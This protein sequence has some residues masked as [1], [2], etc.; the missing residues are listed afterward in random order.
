[1]HKHMTW[2]WTTSLLSLT[3]CSTA[4]AQTFDLSAAERAVRTRDYS[5]ALVLYEQAALGGDAEAQYQLANLLMLGKGVAVNE[6]L[7]LDWLEKAVQQEHPAAQYT[8]ATHNIGFDPASSI[9]LMNLAAAQNYAPARRYLDNLNQDATSE[10]LEGQALVDNWFGA[11]RRNRVDEMQL[12]LNK[13][14]DLEMTDTAQRT[15]LF[16]AIE[17][18]SPEVLSWLLD[19]NADPNHLDKFAV[20]PIFYAINKGDPSLVKTLLQAGANAGATSQNGDNLLH[21]CFGLG[22]YDLIPI[23]VE[24]G[25]PLNALDANGFSALD[26]AVLSGTDVLIQ[27]L[28][29]KGAKHSANWELSRVTNNLDGRQAEIAS[30]TDVSGMQLSDAVKIV[31]SGNSLLLR[32]LLRASPQMIQQQ[33]DDG[34]TLLT[35]S[36]QANQPDIVDVLIAE[37]AGLNFSGSSGRNALLA[38]IRLEST[39]ILKQLLDANADPTELDDD[40]FD[41]ID[42][43]IQYRNLGASQLALGFVIS[44]ETQDSA[45]TDFNRYVRLATEHEMYPLYD[46]LQAHTGRESLDDHSR[47]ALWFAA[48]NSAATEIDQLIRMGVSPQSTDQDGK[49]PLMIAV[50]KNCLVCA[51][52][53]LV[54]SDINQGS[55]SGM[56]PLMLAANAGNES[57]VNWLLNSNFDIDVDA[58]NNQGNTALILAVESD[59]IATAMLLLE[60]GASTSRK[61]NLGY[62]AMDIAKNGHPDIL[63]ELKKYSFLGIF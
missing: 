62:S 27:Q 41:V 6:T 45:T 17:F 19:Q 12:L 13:G 50:E 37:G 2:I 44:N 39:T 22:N 8:L 29:Q 51:Q 55:V 61:N 26:L 1:M 10:K 5:A 7:S 14:A 53:L 43:A 23:L 42:R 40:G 32:K 28:T 46:L 9:E 48:K 34:S 60:A 38:A 15:A 52:K 24:Y 30:A 20:A 33:L 3:L 63:A 31:H 25:A 54:H 58:R 21:Y 35:I 56:T 59:S 11:A 47:N 49:T 4:L 16:T 36:A 18:E 57:I